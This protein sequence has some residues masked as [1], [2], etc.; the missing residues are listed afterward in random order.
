KPYEANPRLNDAAVDAVAVSLEEFGFRQPVVTDARFVIIVGHTRYR[1]ALKL[2]LKKI[3]IHVAKDLSDAQVKA[4]RIADN[5]T[6]TLSEWDMDLLPIEL[7]ALRDE[8]YDLG[9][10]GFDE[11]ELARMM[12]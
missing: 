1:A 5:Q 12:S 10:L 4:Y 11:E 3:P 8:D 6:A 7:L 9:L 2:G